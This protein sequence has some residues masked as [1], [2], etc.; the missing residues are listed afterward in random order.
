ML[1][2]QENPLFEDFLKLRLGM[3]PVDY[4]ISKLKT[5]SKIDDV[6]YLFEMIAGK[7]QLEN[8]CGIPDFDFYYAQA[9]EEMKKMS[10]QKIIRH[11]KLVRDRIPDIIDASGKKCRCEILSKEEYIQK[12]DEKLTEEL[13]EYQQSK[14]LEELADLLEV[15]GAVVKARGYSWEELTELR[16]KKRS[17]RGGFDKRILLK[18]VIE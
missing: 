4:I 13:N 5:N 15:M 9:R 1:T 7:F 8:R 10:Q 14:E 6:Q 12:L 18:E 16:K 2:E 17:E 11:N 3:D